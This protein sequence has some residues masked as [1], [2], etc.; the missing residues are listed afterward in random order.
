MEAP[1]AKNNFKQTVCIVDDDENILEIYKTKFE[2]SGYDVLTAVNG[3]EGLALVRERKPDILLLDIQMPVKNGVEVI[4]EMC[5]DPELK[6]IPIIVLSNVDDEDMF[7]EVGQLEHTNFY[8]IKAL[9]TPQ[10][11]VDIVREVLPS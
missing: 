8:L 10:K 7:R 5:Q 1:S 11:A 2:Q 6:G 4:Q 3:A 9:T